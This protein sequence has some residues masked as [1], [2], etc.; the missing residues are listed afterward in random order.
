[1]T[2]HALAQKLLAGPDL[3]VVI[4]GWASD[5]GFTFEVDEACDDEMSF[6][7]A[8]PAPKDELGYEL[9]RPCISLHYTDPKQ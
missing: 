9:A 2:A 8:T 5:E 6:R 1:M 3:P 7:S 4:N